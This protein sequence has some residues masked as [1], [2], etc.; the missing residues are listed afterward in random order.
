MCAC[1]CRRTGIYPI[2][3]ASSKTTEKGMQ[4]D[5]QRIYS[6]NPLP[7]Q[8]KKGNKATC[9]LEKEENFTAANK[10]NERPI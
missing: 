3:M 8:K 6:S 9:I 4:N 5:K 7:T 1:R 10:I 2:D